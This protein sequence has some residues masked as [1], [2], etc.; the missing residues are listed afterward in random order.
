MIYMTLVVPKCKRSVTQICNLSWMY[1]H[2]TPNSIGCFVLCALVS[3][4]LG[5]PRYSGPG[6]AA[7]PL[8]VVS[9]SAI[10]LRAV[11]VARG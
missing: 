9:A 6:V 4:N 7:V 8:L 1:M 10:F 11:V 3:C 5:W 2:N